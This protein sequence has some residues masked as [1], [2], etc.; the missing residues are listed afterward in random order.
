MTMPSRWISSLVAGCWLVFVSSPVHGDD[1]I[2]DHEQPLMMGEGAAPTADTLDYQLWDAPGR[3]GESPTIVD[4]RETGRFIIS[5]TNSDTWSVNE[6]FSHLGIGEPIAVPLTNDTVPQDLW[7]V[8]TGAAYNHLYNNGRQL[9]LNFSV[10]S[11]SDHPFYSIHETVFRVGANYRLPSGDH[12]AWLFFVNYSNNRYFLNNIPLPGVGYYFQAC[13]NRLQG[14]IGFPF[15]ALRYKP[16]PDWNAQ[17]SI[18]GPRNVN[19]EIGRTIYGPLKAY[20]AFQWGFQEWFIAD[21]QDY[22]DR[23]FY[24]RKRAALGLRSPL[25]GGFLFDVSG[26]RQFDQRFF[27]NDDSTYKDV[28]T[29]GLPAAWFVQTKLSYRFAVVQN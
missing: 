11:D 15:A 4:Q 26:G 12:N 20:T 18:F 19:A 25:P 9:G 17:L 3:S 14:L 22:S 27:V 10:G 2:I 1:R 8:E 6:R 5:R 23:L 24:D 13:D 29:E 28:P 21:R 7:S 16:T